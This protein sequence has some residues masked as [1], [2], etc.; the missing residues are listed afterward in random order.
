MDENEFLDVDSALSEEN[1]QSG[2]GALAEIISDI[3]ERQSRR[4]E[5]TF[6]EG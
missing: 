5:G 4:S 2:S 3:L 1:T 6:G